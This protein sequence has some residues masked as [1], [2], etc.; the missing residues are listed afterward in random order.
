VET[1]SKWE[2]ANKNPPV[3]TAI[4]TTI[5]NCRASFKTLVF[6]FQFVNGALPAESEAL[7]AHLQEYFG[8][9]TKQALLAIVRCLNDPN[10][11]AMAC[12]EA[13]TKDLQAA[14]N[15]PAAVKPAVEEPVVVEKGKRGKSAESKA[16]EVAVESEVA[17]ASINAARLAEPAME[18]LLET[19]L[20]FITTEERDVVEIASLKV[21]VALIRS[22]FSHGAWETF[23]AL[24]E[25]YNPFTASHSNTKIYEHS[26]NSTT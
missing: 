25:L 18:L 1:L 11:R 20:A 21:H 2:G 6:S 7:T 26:C 24:Y 8:G 10:R 14:A 9:N 4:L 22:A 12:L 16:V 13:V 3:P 23:T 5:A 19:A 15:K 17:V